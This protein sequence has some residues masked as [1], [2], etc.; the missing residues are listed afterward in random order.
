[1]PPA[2][3]SEFGRGRAAPLVP[4]PNRMVRT[5]PSH[6]AAADLHR[7]TADFRLLVTVHGL[8]EGPTPFLRNGLP[9]DLEIHIIAVTP[10]AVGAA[11]LVGEGR[12]CAPP[13]LYWGGDLQRHP[14]QVEL[15]GPVHEVLVE[16]A[17]MGQFLPQSEGRRPTQSRERITAQGSLLTVSGGAI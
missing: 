12:K 17:E 5:G 6:D 11:G 14:Q 1:M 7:D 2:R 13:S 4:A 9:P 15:P 16:R 10:A 3:R 8:L